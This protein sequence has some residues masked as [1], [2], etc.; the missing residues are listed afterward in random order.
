MSACGTLFSAEPSVKNEVLL[1]LL[2]AAHCRYTFI[3]YSISI[4]KWARLTTTSCCLSRLVCPYLLLLLFLLFFTFSKLFSFSI[5][6][7]LAWTLSGRSSEHFVQSICCQ[8]VLPFELISEARNNLLHL[9]R[10]CPLSQ[11]LFDIFLHLSPYSSIQLPSPPFDQ[12]QLFSDG[13]YLFPLRIADTHPYFL[14]FAY[15][16]SARGAGNARDFKHVCGEVNDHKPRYAKSLRRYCHS[17]STRREAGS[18]VE[19]C[20]RF[21][22]FSLYPRLYSFEVGRMKRLPLTLLSSLFRSRGKIIEFPL[23]PS[24]RPALKRV[25]RAGLRPT[26]HYYRHFQRRPTTARLASSESPFLQFWSAFSG[27]FSWGFSRSRAT[28]SSSAS[29]SDLRRN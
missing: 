23:S 8:R 9:R 17:R 14:V 5:S 28:Q 25:H 22:G 1:K 15:K 20:D 26:N 19:G 11:P 24:T 18:L 4:S 2:Y 27:S 6:S 10:P 29:S 12:S 7:T 16:N 21:P 3:S 13:T